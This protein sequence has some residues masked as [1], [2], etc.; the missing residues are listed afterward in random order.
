MPLGLWPLPGSL[1]VFE[2]VQNT[3][4]KQWLYIEIEKEN[5]P[6]V[7]LYLSS[8]HPKCMFVIKS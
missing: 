4:T 5:Q 6:L 8:C 7:Q 1:V 2:S 3:F